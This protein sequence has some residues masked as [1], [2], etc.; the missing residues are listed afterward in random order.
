MKQQEALRLKLLKR[1]NYDIKSSIVLFEKVDL[2]VFPKRQAYVAITFRGYSTGQSWF[3]K[4][5]PN[6]PLAIS[7][8]YYSGIIGSTRWGQYEI[9]PKDFGRQ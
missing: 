3:K 8:K 5:I 2:P 9:S 6:L 4:C 1:P 7:F